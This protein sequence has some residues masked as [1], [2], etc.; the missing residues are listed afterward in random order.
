MT[1][2]KGLEPRSLL[3]IGFGLNTPKSFYLKKKAN[4]WYFYYPKNTC[5]LQC[6]K[7]FQIDL[8]NR[9]RT[10]FTAI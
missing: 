7:G 3:F 5:V 10:I 1:P 6:A 9:L 4:N 8:A 2:L